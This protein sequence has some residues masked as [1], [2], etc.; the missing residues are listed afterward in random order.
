MEIVRGVSND[1][2]VEI[3]DILES[4]GFFYDYEVDTAL[5]L[6]DETLRDGESIKGY[7]WLR[8][9]K[10][11]KTVGFTTFGLNPVSSHSWDLYWIA[12]HS[13]QRNQNLGTILLKATEELVKE[14]DGKILWIE[15]SAKPQY[16]STR[17][18]YKKNDY[19]LEATLR[20]FYGPDDSKEIYRKE[21]LGTR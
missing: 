13:D 10:D 9:V 2:R 15:T 17:H 6:V 12:V 21:L 20:D 4:T 19:D 11:G 8:A 3:R 7:Y 5:E 1:S 18:F 16:A 14:M